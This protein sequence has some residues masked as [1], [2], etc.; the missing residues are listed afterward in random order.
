MRVALALVA[1][2][3]SKLLKKVTGFSVTER[4][5]PMQN[6]CIRPWIMFLVLLVHHV[7]SSTCF[8]CINIRL[9]MDILHSSGTCV[10]IYFTCYRYTY[11]EEEGLPD[12]FLND[13]RRH[14]H[15]QRPVTRVCWT[16]LLWHRHFIYQF[17]IQRLHIAPVR[18]K[19]HRICWSSVVGQSMY[20]R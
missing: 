19:S 1:Q 14:S 20:H 2:Q 5:D 7:S 17:K 4:V 12:W 8:Q 10:L 16:K 13:E 18:G 6:Y 15:V 9:S 3:Q 11:G